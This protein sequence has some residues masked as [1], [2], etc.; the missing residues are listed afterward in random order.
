MLSAAESLGVRWN[1]KGKIRAGHVVQGLFM[2][3]RPEQF[4]PRVRTVHDPVESHGSRCFGE[5]T[6]AQREGHGREFR[7]AFDARRP[8]TTATQKESD[9]TTDRR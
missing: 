8:R 2:S 5:A 1:D 9:S 7:R 6:G 3:S 4:P